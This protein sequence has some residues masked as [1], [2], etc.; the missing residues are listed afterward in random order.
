MS[1]LVKIS[2]SICVA[3]VLFSFATPERKV[4]KLTSKIWDDQVVEL[5]KM[6]VPDSLRGEVNELYAV[7]SENGE[8]LGYACD[9]TAFG[10]KVGGC[11]APSNPNVQS[12]ETFDYIVI[13]NTDFEIKKVDISNYG[14][15]YGYEICRAKWLK[16]F[17][18]ST[19]DFKLNDNIDGI[20]GATVSAQ[21]LIDDLNALGTLLISSD[22]SSELSAATN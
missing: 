20:S 9:A 22:V 5:E 2:L 14:G 4:E 8:V 13:Y 21:F 17:E 10:C 15:Q 3:I 6:E 18:G 16:Q 11:A 1:T 12:Y 7:K 19:N